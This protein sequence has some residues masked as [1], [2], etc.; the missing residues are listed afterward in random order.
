MG[1]RCKAR[2]KRE[3]ISNPIGE[4]LLFIYNNYN[5]KKKLN[6][7]V[8]VFSK[9]QKNVILASLYGKIIFNVLIMLLGFFFSNLPSLNCPFASPLGHNFFI[10]IL[11]N[12]NT[13][14]NNLHKMYY[15]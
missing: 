3:G 11:Y 2:I 14:R 15:I 12:T 1:E 8:D 4:L 5:R 7:K 9:K 10:R 13:M 6:S